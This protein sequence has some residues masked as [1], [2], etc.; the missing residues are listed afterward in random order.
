MN[1]AIVEDDHNVADSLCEFVAR[2]STESGE[3]LDVDV[4]YDGLDFLDKFKGQYV[5]ILM[6]IE[7]PHS[8]GMDVARKVREL[9]QV[10]VIIFITNLASYA[11]QGYSVDALDYILKPVAYQ[12]FAFRFRRAISEIMRGDKKKIQICSEKTI[13]NID[14]DSVYY[15]EICGHLLIVHTMEGN[16]DAWSTL[17]AVEKRLPFGQFA[18]CDNCYLVNLKHVKA[19]NKDSVIVGKDVLKISRNRRKSFL[20]S[21]TDYI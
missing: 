20:A 8:N 11:I 6:D 7:L 18:R 12:S 14:I 1:V 9:D 15:F 17:S 4:Y 5:I 3:E 19:I 10:V 16:I 21:L 2:Y 13:L